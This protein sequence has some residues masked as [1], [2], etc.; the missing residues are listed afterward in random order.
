MNKGAFAVI[1]RENTILLVRSRMTPRYLNHW[2]FPGGVVDENEK[3]IDAAKREVM[4]ETGITCRP[5]ELLSVVENIGSDIQISIF[6]ADYVDGEIEI[7][8]IEIAEARWVNIEDIFNIPLA[9]DNEKIL[10]K[11]IT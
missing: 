5:N 4:E 2:S 8:P 3:L 11:L 10:R 6:R 1:T 9:Y 7:D